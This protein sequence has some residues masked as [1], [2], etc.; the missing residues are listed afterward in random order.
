MTFFSAPHNTT[1]YTKLT[2]FCHLSLLFLPTHSMNDAGST[3]CGNSH[4]TFGLRVATFGLLLFGQGVGGRMPPNH[5]FEPVQEFGPHAAGKLCNETQCRGNGKHEVV[6]QHNVEVAKPLQL[7][8]VAQQ[9]KV[10]QPCKIQQMVSC[11]KYHNF[12][13]TKQAHTSNKINQYHIV[14]KKTEHQQYHTFHNTKQYRI[15]NVIFSARLKI[16]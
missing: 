15:S 8:K 7:A 12:S 14:N 3:S 5:L 6:R 13:N 10:R 4:V 11:Y 9:V 2:H 16:K 1:N